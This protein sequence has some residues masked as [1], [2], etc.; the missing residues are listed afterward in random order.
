MVVSRL[1]AALSSFFRVGRIGPCQTSM[2]CEEGSSLNAA[3]N[4][5][6]LLQEGEDSLLSR[7]L[8]AAVGSMPQA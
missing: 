2:S 5:G 8:A 4:Y 3:P 7:L 1:K 6:S